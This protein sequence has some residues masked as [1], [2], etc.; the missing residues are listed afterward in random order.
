MSRSKKWK[1]EWCFF[2][3]ENGRRQYNKVCRRCVHDCKQS[4]RTDLIV[5]PMYRS[6]EAKTPP[7]RVENG[8]KSSLYH[9]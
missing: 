7:K 1:K 3:G 2:F 4:F 5:C 8:Q 9:P 6:K